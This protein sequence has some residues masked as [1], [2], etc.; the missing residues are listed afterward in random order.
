MGSLHP[1]G[2]PVNEELDEPVGRLA[3]YTEGRI[4]GSRS[5]LKFCV[6]TPVPEL[7]QIGGV[8]AGWLFAGEKKK[9]RRELPGHQSSDEVGQD[10]VLQNWWAKRS[11][12]C[13]T[14]GAGL[15]LVAKVLGSVRRPGKA[16]ASAS[17]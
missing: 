9:A 4:H 6:C 16:A 1:I 17:A 15:R 3:A 10:E 5:F 12:L 11:R 13:L 8:L 14:T 2:A 7:G